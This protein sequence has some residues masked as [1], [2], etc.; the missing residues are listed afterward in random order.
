VFRNTIARTLIVV[1]SLGFTQLAKAQ[2]C[3]ATHVFF[4][5]GID[6]TFDEA[7]DAR[8]ELETAVIAQYSP[9]SRPTIEFHRAYNPTESFL[10]DLVEAGEQVMSGQDEWTLYWRNMFRSGPFVAPFQSVL[11]STIRIYADL[12]AIDYIP[13]LNAHAADYR[14]V[15][16]RGDRVIVVAHSQGN[17]FA[18]A[19][20]PL[21][22]DPDFRIV[23]VANPASSVATPNTTYTTLDEDEA[24]V[25]ISRFRVALGF[26]PSQ[27]ANFTNLPTVGTDPTGHSF[28]DSYLQRGYQETDENGSRQ[29]ILEQIVANVRPDSGTCSPPPQPG[30]A[31]TDAFEVYAGG[32]FPASGGWAIRPGAS[33]AGTALQ[34][35]STSAANGGAQSLRLVGAANLGVNVHR[36][37][38]LPANRR[39]M[40]EGYVNT[41]GATYKNAYLGVGGPPAGGDLGAVIRFMANGGLADASVDPISGSY[42]TNTWTRLRVIVNPATG[43][44]SAYVGDMLVAQDVPTAIPSNAID[45][46]WLAVDNSGVGGLTGTT[47]YFDDIS[48]V[49]CGS[50]VN[51][52][53][54]CPTGVRPA[55]VTFVASG[56]VSEVRNSSGLLPFYFGTAPSV[57]ETFSI[58]YTFDATT[59]DSTVNTTVGTFAPTIREYSVTVGSRPP[60]TFSATELTTNQIDTRT[61]SQ[62]LYQ[63]A[64]G[65]PTPRTF[66]SVIS[67]SDPGST[68]AGSSDA[69]PLAPPIPSQYASATMNFA[70]TLGGGVDAVIGTVTSIVA[71]P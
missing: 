7:G 26:E 19:A 69:L 63:V 11:R 21:M 62:S 22:D 18:N 30:T 14:S 20:A 49:D 61:T 8:R 39:Y 43:L 50:P 36:A 3:L 35:V 34:V 66:S 52:A 58:R 29:R 40:M 16:S 53:D 25:E 47:A 65:G 15:L 24:I 71:I 1:C 68:A 2:Q 44:Y 12:N 13:T 31:F 67:L 60:V 10:R 42:T 4:G 32:D 6:T 9:S 59:V 64:V 27:P 17:F 46:V 5:N 41:T 38:V 54:A 56:V 23:S 55:A 57:G 28:L 51:G 37:V 45:R 70:T 48:V 33:G